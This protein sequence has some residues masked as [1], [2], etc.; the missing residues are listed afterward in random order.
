MRYFII[1]IATYI[2]LVN[3]TAF[4]LYGVDKQKAKKHLWRIPEATLIG[5][6]LL[7]GSVGA[8]TGMRVFHHKTRHIKFYVGIPVILVVQLICIT[9]A[10]S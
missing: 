10:C 4:V 6:A 5:V 3:L 2:V 1:G 7:G 9:A 8:L